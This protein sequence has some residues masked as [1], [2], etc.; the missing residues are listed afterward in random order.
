MFQGMPDEAPKRHTIVVDS[1]QRI[2]VYH[3]DWSVTKWEE[4][5]TGEARC[6]PPHPARCAWD[7]ETYHKPDVSEWEVEE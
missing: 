4:F 1:H 2:W 7:G 5:L 3:P 6:S